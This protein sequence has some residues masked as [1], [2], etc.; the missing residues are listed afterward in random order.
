MRSWAILDIEPNSVLHV[1]FRGL[2]TVNNPKIVE[3]DSLLENGGR[4]HFRGKGLF[5]VGKKGW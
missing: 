4:K 1:S 5:F 3:N 2:E